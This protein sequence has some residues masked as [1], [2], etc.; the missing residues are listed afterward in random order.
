MGMKTTVD[1][2]KR[3]EEALD[4][5]T[6]LTQLEYVQLALA[7]LDQ[8]G[9]AVR[10]LHEWRVAIERAERRGARATIC[11]NCGAIVA[12]NVDCCETKEGRLS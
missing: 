2:T 7:S 4:A 10:D 1:R 5:L 12:H 9:V 8:A 6:G 3:Y 11:A